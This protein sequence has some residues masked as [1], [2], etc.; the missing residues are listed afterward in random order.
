[1]MEANLEALQNSMQELEERREDLLRR[2]TAEEDKGLQRLAQ[3]Q[4]WLS[5][6]NVS[7]SQVNDL[8]KAK[9]LQ[10]ERLCLC[11]YCSKNFMSGRDYGK[12]VMK[13]L[14]E[15]K[16]LVSKGVFKVVADK[17]P[18]PK[19]EKKHIQT[20]V[21]LDTM[22]EKAW[23]RLMKDGPRTM[24]LYGMGGVGKTT[25]LACIN[26]KF[27]E[28]TNGFDVVIWVV[29]SKDLQNEGIQEQILGRLGLHREWKQETAKEKASYIYNFLNVKKFVLLL[30]DLWSEVDLEKIGVPPLTQE[31]ESK[32]VFTTRSREVCKDMEVDDEMKVDCLP[33]DEAWELFEKKV[34]PIPLKSHQ[35]IPTLARKVAEKCCGL[36]LALSVIG[37]AMASRET[38]QEWHH[39]IHVLNSS[40]HEFPSMEEK[41]LP[42][43]KFSYDSLKDEKVKQCFLYCSLFPEDYEVKKEELIEY[44]ICEGFIDGDGDEEEEDGAINKGHDIIGSLVRAHLL[45]DG[46]LTTKVKMHD[47]IREMALWIASGFGKQKETICVK[48]GAQLRHIPKDINWETLRRMSLMSNQIGTM[49]RSD[50]CPNLSTLLLQ[51]NKLVDISGGFFRFMPALVVLDLSRN[52]SLSRLPEEVSN[53]GSLQYLN[54]STTGIKRLPASLKELKKLINLNLEFTDELQSIVGIASSLPNLQVL[55][56]FSSRVCI[57]ISL[58]EEL[59]LLENLSL[60]TATVNDA[61]VLENIQGVDRLVSS[62]RALCIKNMSAPVIVLNTVALNGLQHVEIVCS[63]IL[64]IKIDWE[65]KGTG[66]LQSTSSAGFQHLSTVEIFNLQG[67]RDLTWLLFAQNLKRLSVTLSLTIEEII[68]MEKGM[69]ITNAHPDILVP[70]GKLEFLEVRGLDELKRICWNPP[71]LPNLRQFDVRSCLKLPEAAT[72]FPRHAEE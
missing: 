56:L 8:L 62:I 65:S 26:N 41:I 58:M 28:V 27:L 22:V 49:S 35:E 51:N 54:L 11:G 15:V 42:I 68:N 44:W 67:P 48:S 18:A 43:L 38:V 32:I 61:L 52:L 1:M 34:G 21:G 70:F 33:R 31:N 10:T 47:V 14:S 45:M 55:K 3:V 24:G 29:V 66:E 71:A 53:L 37:K 36:P 17:V 63:Q 16:G 50:N 60:L 19:V 72:E 64:E 25:L 23:N 7:G 57:D 39:V 2:V 13:T 12:K 5:R 46:E 30:D 59:L 40:S 69:D 4:G 9:S 6:V 20:T